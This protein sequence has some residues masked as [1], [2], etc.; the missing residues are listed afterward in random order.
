MWF[1]QWKYA[2]YAPLHKQI[3]R[4]VLYLFGIGVRFEI[5]R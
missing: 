4:K 2:E 1:Q 3:L 5:F